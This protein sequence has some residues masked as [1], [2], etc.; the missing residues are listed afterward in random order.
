MTGSRRIWSRTRRG[1]MERAHGPVRPGAPD[2]LGDPSRRTAAAFAVRSI[3]EI[4]AMDPSH[5]D[6]FYGSGG[7][8]ALL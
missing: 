6:S 1:L 7:K 5:F 8:G 4:A 2:A 3:P